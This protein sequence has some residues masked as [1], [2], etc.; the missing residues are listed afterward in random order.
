MSSKFPQQP[1][2]LGRPKYKQNKLSI[3]KM[4]QKEKGQTIG[5]EQLFM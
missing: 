4:K 3:W 5:E 1:T 2:W